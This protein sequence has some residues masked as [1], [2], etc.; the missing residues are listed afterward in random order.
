MNAWRTIS[1]ALQANTSGYVSDLKGA[2]KATDELGRSVDKSVGDGGK[3]RRSYGERAKTALGTVVSWGRKLGPVAGGITAIGAATRVLKGGY[4]RMTT[5][6]DGRAA[7]EVSLGDSSKAA[8]L[9]DDVLGVVTDTPFNLDH[10][11]EAAQRMVGMGVA[12]SKVPTYLEAIGEAAATQGG[13]ADAMADRLATTF[14]QIA[15]A[16]RI[17]GEDIRSFQRAG[18]NALAILGNEFGVTAAEMR[19]MV[20]EGVVPADRALDALSKGIIEGSDGAAGATAALGGSMEALRDTVS[21]SVGGIG[22]AMDRVGAALLEPFSPLIVSAAQGLAD[23]MD[24]IGDAATAIGVPLADAVSSLGSLIGEAAKQLGPLVALFGKLAGAA[25]LVPLEGVLSAVSKLAGYAADS[26]WAVRLLAGAMGALV[27]TKIASGV[28]GLTSGF[29]GLVDSVRTYYGV[30]KLTAQDRGVS[31]F[32]QGVAEMSGST[33]KAAV[34]FGKAAG[35]MVAL[36]GAIALGSYAWDEYRAPARRA[37]Q[38]QQDLTDAMLETGDAA[39]AMRE[40]L[41]LTFAGSSG[42]LELFGD[43]A[44]LQSALDTMGLSVEGFVERMDEGTESV[45]GLEGAF[46]DLDTTD[47]NMWELSALKEA[48]DG[49]EGAKDGVDAYTAA[50][51][52]ADGSLARLV[53]N[54]N[55]LGIEDTTDI[56]DLRNRTMGLADVFGV[57]ADNIDDWILAALE[58]R[59]GKDAI[60]ETTGMSPHVADMAEAFDDLAEATG[61]SR[62]EL[63]E[64][65][66]LA[67]IIIG[68]PKDW[69]DANREWIGTLHDLNEALEESGGNLNIHTVE[70]RKNQK[71]ISDAIDVALDGAIAYGGLEEGVGDAAGKL[72]DMRDSLVD[73]IAEQTESRDVAVQMVDKYGLTEEAVWALGARSEEHTSELQSR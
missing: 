65:A 19:K 21:G 27:A 43:G 47:L 24:G 55:N 23:A 30:I 13:E 72:D 6:Q 7:L 51:E 73:T 49:F 18:V 53:E 41:A 58:T 28:A 60:T 61:D 59:A 29:A 36:T 10:F 26:E 66:E 62:D 16:G 15:A 44:A 5:L 57:G 35:R 52:D 14:G 63:S 71:M 69:E 39:D 46:Q 34:G 64:W 33:R 8:A 38:N 37:E 32:R 11:A 68:T 22:A 45:R 31:T 50:V 54:L 2:A 42:G 20:S 56:E 67:N 40:K 9:M 70:G 48:I 4:D 1:V 3:E 25:V 17:T 12:A